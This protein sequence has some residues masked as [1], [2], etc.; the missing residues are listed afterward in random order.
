[1]PGGI[2]FVAKKTPDPPVENWVTHFDNTEWAA[3]TGSWDGSKWVGNPTSLTL[4]PIG[5]WTD[6]YRP[7]KIRLATNVGDLIFQ[8]E[9]TDSNTIADAFFYVSLTPVII[10]WS[11]NLDIDVFNFVIDSGTLNITNIEFLEE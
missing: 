3:S 2:F 11:N 4:S 8:L 1:M 5:T 9:D 10:D 6:N 7:T